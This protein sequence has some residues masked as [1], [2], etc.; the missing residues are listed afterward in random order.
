MSNVVDV[1]A[2]SKTFS[3]RV[4]QPGLGG[5]V[6][7]LLRPQWETIR[8]VGE[9]SFAMEDAETLALIG[10]NGAGKSTTIKI[11]TGIMHPT[12]GEATVLGLVPWRQRTH[13]GDE[14]RH[15]VRAALA[16]LVS[17]AG[18]RNVRPAGATS[19]R[20]RP[21]S[22]VPGATSWC[23]A[24]SSSRCSAPRCASC[25]SDSACA[26]RSPRRCCTGHAILFLDEPT[27]GLDVIA[28]QQIRELIRELN[29]EEGVAVLL[30]SHDAGD[31]E[32]LCKR[33]IVINHGTDDAS[34]IA[35]ARC[36][37]AT[38]GGR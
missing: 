3:R 29:R 33:V 23:A 15:R 17:P 1:Q 31:I 2:L 9:L 21:P 13:A 28:K 22:I 38:C 19:M 6:G 16:A 34:T 4:R 37:G 14:Y 11:L 24:S 35:S 10:P 27:I 18:R 36:G 5:A 12:T 32:Q 26:A 8:A 20:S 30:T 25:R 7:S